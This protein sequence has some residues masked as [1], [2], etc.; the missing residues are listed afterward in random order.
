M[1][2]SRAGMSKSSHK[3]LSC[4]AIHTLTCVRCAMDSSCFSRI[5]KLVELVRACLAGD[6][7]CLYFLYHVFY[8]FQ[9]QILHIIVIHNIKPSTGKGILHWADLYF[10][11]FQSLYF[12]LYLF[13]SYSLAQASI[14]LNTEYYDIDMSKVIQSSSIYICTVKL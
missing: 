1:P 5:C 11:A 2:R 12:S 9:R 4:S 14:I 7:I 8:F 3:G 10:L 6:F 13:F